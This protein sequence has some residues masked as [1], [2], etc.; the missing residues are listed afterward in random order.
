MNGGADNQTPA[1]STG[2]TPIA[3]GRDGEDPQRARRTTPD[4]GSVAVVAGV[5]GLL[6][7]PFLIA[8]PTARYIILVADVLALA[9]GGWSL[10]DGVVRRSGH[11]DMGIAAVVAGG[12]SLYLFISYVSGPPPGGT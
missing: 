12:V 2:P 4:L 7:G 5:V 11:L 9:L 6:A 8:D 10:W 3:H 1:A